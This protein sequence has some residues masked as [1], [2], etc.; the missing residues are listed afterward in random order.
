MTTPPRFRVAVTEDREAVLA[1]MD[2]FN[3]SQGYPTNPAALAPAFDHFVTHPELGRLWLIEVRGAPVGYL[4]VAFGW[5]F[6]F[7]GR[8]AFV[9][10]F[11]LEAS[12]RGRGW[13]EQALVFAIGEAERLGVRALHLE[14]EPDNPARR[15]YER[16]GF[17]PDGRH[18]LSRPTTP[19]DERGTR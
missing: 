13:G 19:P 14:V 16:A 2:R 3:L 12:A 7:H 10:E 6:E 18:L 17:R 5:S 11:F 8:D 1:M 15:L 9:D 4:V